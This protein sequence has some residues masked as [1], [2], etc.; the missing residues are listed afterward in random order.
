MK[1]FIVHAHH[2]P[3]S[4][5]SAL[6]QRAAEAFKSMG[7]EVTVSDLH[8]MNFD[9]VSDR[10]NF[11]TTKDGDYLKQQ[12]EE[13]H[14][15]EVGGF[16]EDVE[17]EIKKLEECD[18]LVFSF[19]L[20]WFGVPAIMK[21]WFD[22]V[23]AMGRVYGGKKLYENGI[24]NSQKRGLIITTTGGGAQYYDGWGFNPEL[25]TI[26]TPIQHGIFWFNGILPLEP[27]VAWSPARIS[28]DERIE[29]LDKLEDRLKNVFEE[30]HIH[31]PMMGDFMSGGDDK[32]RFNVVIKRTKPVDENYMK[33]VPKE[34]Q[35]AMEMKREGVLL[36]LD[37][38]AP[39]DSNWRA[40]LK[41]RV[42][43]EAEAKKQ[44]ER[45]PLHDYF[46]FEITQI[47]NP[48]TIQSKAAIK[49]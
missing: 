47:V 21:G 36:E 40:F 20:W 5:C 19:P 29:Y 22:K 35:T 31:M 42:S 34:M 44:L 15:T 2:E 27:F 46:E 45:L 18:L 9:P 14:A 28:N 41:L 32:K 37:L 3:Q 4:F 33:L 6:S 23:L 11:K 1:V 49:A 12:Q 39:D 26:M 38:A 16:S 7:H 17:A 48:R 43:D 13:M 8:K 24:G 10:R 30:E 25:V